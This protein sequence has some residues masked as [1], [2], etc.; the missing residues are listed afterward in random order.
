MQA[1]DVNGAKKVR[2]FTITNDLHLKKNFVDIIQQAA[3]ATKVSAYHN[4]CP[5]NFQKEK[6]YFFYR[7]GTGRV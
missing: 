4:Q 7:R 6:R 1:D 5:N 2:I 3:K